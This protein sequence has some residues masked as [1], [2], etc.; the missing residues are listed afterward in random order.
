MKKSTGKFGIFSLLLAVSILISAILIF[1]VTDSNFEDTLFEY[2]NYE[3][4]DVSNNE[5][6]TNVNFD[7]EV[8]NDNLEGIV[9]GNSEPVEIIAR[10]SENVKHY[11]MPDGTIKAVVYD[12]AIHRKDVDGVWQDIDN[13]LSVVKGENRDMYSTKDGRVVFAGEYSPNEEIWHLYEDDSEIYMSYIPVGT[14]KHSISTASSNISVA[15]VQNRNSEVLVFDDVSKVNSTASVVYEISDGVSFEYILDG[16]NIKE[17]IIVTKEQD[18][19]TYSFKLS[20]KGLS[21]I[22]NADG[23]ISFFNNENNLLKYTIP[24]PFMFDSN[25]VRSDDV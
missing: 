11:L 4:L 19:Y 14:R 23:S 13:T 20:L 8:I 7:E 24:T 1:A 2:Q 21:A 3:N 12:N 17:K 15:S 9:C 16:N 25:G 10:R 5:T 18:D 6:A 22:V